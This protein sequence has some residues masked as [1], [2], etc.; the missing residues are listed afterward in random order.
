MNKKV[1]AVILSCF[2]LGAC[3]GSDAQR[4]GL[5]LDVSAF[6]ERLYQELSYRDQLEELDPLILYTLLGIDGS[7]VLEQKNYFSSGATAEELI[8][9]QAADA[10]ALRTLKRAVE[11]RIKDQSSLYASYAPGEVAYLKAAVLEEKGDYLVYCVSSD[12]EAARKMVEEAL[13]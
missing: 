4:S 9:F 10:D 6:G 12:E 3:G 5:S 1:A 13:R 8:V 2:L 11:G 7:H